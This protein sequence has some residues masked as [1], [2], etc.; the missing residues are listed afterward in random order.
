MWLSYWQL[1]LR[2]RIV[3]KLHLFLHLICTPLGQVASD[4]FVCLFVWLV[5]WLSLFG[6]VRQ[7]CWLLSA[8]VFVAFSD[9]TRNILWKRKETVFVLIFAFRTTMRRGDAWRG[10]VDSSDFGTKTRPL[11]SRRTAVVRPPLSL[12]VEPPAMFL[13]L[14]CFAAGL[15]RRMSVSHLL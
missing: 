7:S 1:L 10:E 4:S 6:W 2:T 3:N 8:S 9:S 14:V 5:G 11:P 12:P 13:L 15:I